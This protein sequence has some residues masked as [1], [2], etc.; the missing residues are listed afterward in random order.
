MTIY[1]KNTG[2]AVP[3]TKTP[4]CLLGS[5]HLSPCRVKIDYPAW[6]A[7]LE[8]QIRQMRDALMLAEYDLRQLGAW[9]ETYEAIKAAL[10]V[11]P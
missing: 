5:T 1:I 6:T 10:R 4:H 7:E 11:K 8:K 3:C 2:H 9:G